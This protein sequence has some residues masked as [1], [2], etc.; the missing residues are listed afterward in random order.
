MAEAVQNGVIFSEP[1]KP[2]E[3]GWGCGGAETVRSI[4]SNIV[5]FFFFL[6]KIRIL[7]FLTQSNFGSLTQTVVSETRVMKSLI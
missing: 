2:G 7:F 5:L 1:N 4:L 6:E 3:L